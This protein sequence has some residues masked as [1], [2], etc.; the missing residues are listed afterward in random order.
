MKA[1]SSN[2]PCLQSTCFASG[3]AGALGVR[4][5]WSTEIE[6][7]AVEAGACYVLRQRRVVSKPRNVGVRSNVRRVHLTHAAE[8]TARCNTRLIVNS[9]CLTAS[10]TRALSLSELI[11]PCFLCRSIH[12]GSCGYGYMDENA[13]TGKGCCLQLCWLN[14]AAGSAN[15]ND[16]LSTVAASACKSFRMSL[17]SCR[18]T[19]LTVFWDGV[20]LCRLGRRS[21]L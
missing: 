1:V 16:S 14:T 3:A 21:C 13:G 15:L 12:T 11:M 20:L 4:I 18:K 6:R 9:T 17:C 2:V 8:H 5:N 19:L 7:G 10:I